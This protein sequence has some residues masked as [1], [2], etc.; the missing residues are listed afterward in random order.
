MDG[1]RARPCGADI[2]TLLRMQGLG[3]INNG[4]ED[5]KQHRPADQP[6]ALQ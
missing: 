6:D 1:S 3:G 5:N 2:D 4:G